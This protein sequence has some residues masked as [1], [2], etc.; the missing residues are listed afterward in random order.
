LQLNNTLL[1]EIAFPFNNGMRIVSVNCLFSQ[2]R[3]FS[4]IRPLRE[5]LLRSMKD[6]CPKT[7]PWHMRVRIALQPK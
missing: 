2:L 1:I 3:S 7:P 5:T 6:T 4:G